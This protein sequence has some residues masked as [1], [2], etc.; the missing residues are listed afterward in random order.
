MIL[1]YTT[2]SC[3]G[4]CFHAEG[5]TPDQAQEVVR[6]A[7]AW[8]DVDAWRARGGDGTAEI[9]PDGEAETL[10]AEYG[11]PEDGTAERVSPERLVEIARLGPWRALGY[12]A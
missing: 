3:T 7:E 1:I 2:A 6:G 9:R 8:N 4:F 5:L 10:R 12:E 11:E